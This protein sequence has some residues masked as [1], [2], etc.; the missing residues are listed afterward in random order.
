MLRRSGRAGGWKD[1]LT[2]EQAKRI[3]RDHREQMTRFGYL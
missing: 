3:E 1:E 2:P